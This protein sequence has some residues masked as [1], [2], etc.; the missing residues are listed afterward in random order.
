MDE[1]RWH[2]NLFALGFQLLLRGA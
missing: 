2:F 1:M